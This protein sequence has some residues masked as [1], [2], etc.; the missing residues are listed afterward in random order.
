[1]KYLIFFLPVIMI[2]FFVSC[3]ENPN[4]TVINNYYLPDSLT[5]PNVQPR[6]V[7]TNPANNAVGPFVNYNRTSDFYNITANPQK[8]FNLTNL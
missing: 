2:F 4:D 7:F 3:K 1:M 5:N 8:R 6:V